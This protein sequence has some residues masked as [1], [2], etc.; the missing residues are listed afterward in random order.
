MIQTPGTIFL[1]TGVFEMGRGGRGPSF[2]ATQKTP[3]A[4]AVYTVRCQSFRS[5]RA[6]TLIIGAA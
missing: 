2:A 4:Y 6:V 3:D 1:Q 5:I